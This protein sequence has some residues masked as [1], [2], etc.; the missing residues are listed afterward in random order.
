MIKRYIKELGIQT[1]GQALMAWL[2]SNPMIAC[3]IPATSKPSR[4]KENAIVGN[5]SLPKE[6]NEYILQEATRCL[7]AGD[8]RLF[9]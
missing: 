4:I 1:W 8:Y 6:L 3:I 2:I 9:S 5:I 7:K